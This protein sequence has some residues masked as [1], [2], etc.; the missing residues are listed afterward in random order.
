MPD[1]KNIPETPRT[2]PS[3]LQ[4]NI[5]DKREDTPTKKTTH[6]T[7]TSPIATIVFPKDNSKN[8][9]VKITA[10]NDRGSE[11]SE[12]SIMSTGNN[13]PDSKQ[14]HPNTKERDATPQIFHSKTGNSKQES[15]TQSTGGHPHQIAVSDTSLDW[16]KE[17]NPKPDILIREPKPNQNKPRATITSNS[18]TPITKDSTQDASIPTMIAISSSEDGLENNGD[19]PMA[20]KDWSKVS[21]PYQKSKSGVHISTPTGNYTRKTSRSVITIEKQDQSSHQEITI[22]E[23]TTQGVPPK[24][25]RITTQSPTMI[26]IIPQH[27]KIP[28]QIVATQPLQKASTHRDLNN[29]VQSN[30]RAVMPTPQQTPNAPT[31]QTT[32]RGKCDGTLHQ[33]THMGK[34][35]QPSTPDEPMPHPPTPQRPKP[36]E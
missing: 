34:S 6:V 7:T 14:T 31:A 33:L 8:N 10:R 19:Q 12:T 9:V 30:T 21:I 28:Q 36:R 16:N 17:E 2:H 11:S 4:I 15:P 27:T 25:I 35:V 22:L 23:D 29:N 5:G 18:K 1:D 3:D 32:T 26:T 24:E 13:S 20:Q